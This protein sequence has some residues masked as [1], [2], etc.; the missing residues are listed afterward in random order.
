MARNIK[1]IADRL[2]AQNV[3]QLAETGGDAFGAAR[4]SALSSATPVDAEESAFDLAS[5]AGLIGCIKGVPR[6]P[7]DLSIK[8]K[9]MECFGRE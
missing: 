1:E 8:L 4:L 2:D 3:G 5:R 9:H 7:T 6:S